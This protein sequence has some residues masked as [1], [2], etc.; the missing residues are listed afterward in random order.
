MENLTLAIARNST[1]YFKLTVETVDSNNEIIKRDFVST[2]YIWERNEKYWVYYF[3][4]DGYIDLCINFLI[5]YGNLKIQS[6]FND[7]ALF[8]I[9]GLTE[10]QV[11]YGVNGVFINN[12]SLTCSVTMNTNNGIVNITRKGPDFLAKIL[13]NNVSIAPRYFAFQTGTAYNNARVMGTVSTNYYSGSNYSLAFEGNNLF[14]NYINNSL[15]DLLDCFYV[16]CIYYNSSPVPAVYTITVTE[17]DL[18]TCTVD[19]EEAEEGETITVTC[20]PN[21][22]YK[23]Y[24]VFVVGDEVGRVTT[25]KTS[26]NVQTFTM[27]ADN[28]KVSA[29]FV[30]IDPYRPG[31]DTQPQDRGE[32]TFDNTSDEIITPD[33]LTLNYSDSGLVRLFNPDSSKLKDFGDF[34]WSNL[35]DYDTIKKAFSNPMDQIISLHTIPIGLS[36]TTEEEVV[37]GGIGS[38]V[39]MRPLTKQ[40][41]KVNMGT[42]HIPR[43]YATAL[44]YSPFTRL[45]LYLPFIGEKDI[46]ADEVMGKDL[47]VSYQIDALSGAAVAYVSISGQLVYMFSGNV[48]QYI[49]VSQ[50]NF[51]GIING[52]TGIAGAIASVAGGI[53]TLT[54]NPAIGA[55]MSAVGGTKSERNEA[56]AMQ[57]RHAQ[58]MNTLGG[59]EQIG[60][61]AGNLVNALT[62]KPNTAHIGLAQGVAGY[63]SYPTPYVLIKRPHQSLA[64][65]FYSQYGY[66]ANLSL[67]LAELS[68]FCKLASIDITSFPGTASEL[69]ELKHILQSGF[70][71]R[72]NTAP[73]Y[74]TTSGLTIAFEHSNSETNACGKSL[75]TVA[76]LTGELRQES[77]L[78]NPVIDIQGNIESYLTANEVCIPTFYRRYFITEWT[79]VRKNL[80]RIHLHCDVLQSFWDDIKSA[81]CIVERYENQWTLDLNDPYFQVS[82]DLLMQQLKFTSSFQLSN[83]SFVL[84]IAGNGATII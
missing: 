30:S 56:R 27:P 67:N 70:Y 35:I 8:N 63:M 76:A 1:F 10:N 21:T 78:L 12:S 44:D 3:D 45:Q 32:G 53:L 83:S 49:P 16:H 55:A 11:S 48:A 50:S 71:I 41:Y 75:T 74:T 19:K 57:M 51:S 24:D 81:P 68:G 2:P 73:T 20:A 14:S 37:F 40:F 29:V 38:G 17:S 59:V 4:L 43:F 13:P 54:G 31:G 61:G 33:E 39:L 47:S 52:V 15:S 5:S 23:L 22:G 64:T 77:D 28:V 18:G 80:F 84:A 60:Q 26:L 79:A 25:E 34:L 66:P 46:D 42:L 6:D 69:A 65:N 82:Q 62:G 36:T 72:G 9:T 58:T 7:I